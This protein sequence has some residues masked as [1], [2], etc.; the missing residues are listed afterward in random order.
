[1]WPFPRPIAFSIASPEPLESVASKI[2]VALT[3]SWKGFAREGLIGTVKACEV[4]VG[5]YRPRRRLACGPRFYGKLK[6]TE[7][8]TMLA[9]EFDVTLG[10]KSAILLCL[11]GCLYNAWRQLTLIHRNEEPRWHALLLVF[12]LAL[13]LLCPVV[14]HV[15]WRVQQKDVEEIK[16]FLE[17]AMHTVAYSEGSPGDYGT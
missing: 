6:K 8:G 7:G 16:R 14:M 4:H 1:M 9:G 12:F 5:K 11:V 10:E 2:E 15:G 13:L 3:L 17:E